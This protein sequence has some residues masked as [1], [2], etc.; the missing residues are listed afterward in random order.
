MR[1]E[2]PSY[3]YQQPTETE[4]PGAVSSPQKSFKNKIKDNIKEKFDKVKE[5][6]GKVFSKGQPQVMERRISATPP[7]QSEQKPIIKEESQS[8]QFNQNSRV[9][10]VFNE[11]LQSSHQ[12]T[13]AP[14]ILT[15]KTLENEIV[16]FKN[17]NLNEELMQEIHLTTDDKFLKN[18]S[19]YLE[20]MMTKANPEEKKLLT[21][22]INYF[23][24]WDKEKY[25]TRVDFCGLLGI[26]RPP[27]EDVE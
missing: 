23:K 24:I 18:K 5:S 13:S 15:L 3:N 22:L 9:S 27:R 2:G 25:V 7:A 6:W 26:T 14:V 1:T 20:N 11:S 19:N 10:S 4:Q 16:K 8:L 21:L 12:T 17:L